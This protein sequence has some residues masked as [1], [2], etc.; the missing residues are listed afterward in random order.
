MLFEF[1]PAVDVVASPLG[2]NVGPTTTMYVAP[3]TP[4]YDG[5]SV[6]YARLCVAGE[7][8]LLNFRHKLFVVSLSPIFFFF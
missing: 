7:L 4:I 6:E 3:A 5:D 2:P 1:Q 8:E